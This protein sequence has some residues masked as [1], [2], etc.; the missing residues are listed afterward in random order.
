MYDKARKKN[1]LGTPF[2]ATKIIMMVQA[3]K[4]MLTGPSQRKIPAEP[5][6]S[7]QEVQEKKNPDQ[8]KP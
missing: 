5:K 7:T 1:T 8:E 6:A 3:P 2:I 4:V